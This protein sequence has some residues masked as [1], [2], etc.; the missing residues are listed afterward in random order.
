MKQQVVACLSCVVFLT[1]VTFCQQTSPAVK[2]ELQQ[3][4]AALN[5]GDFVAAEQHFSAAVKLAPTAA[6]PHANLGLA[7][8]RDRQYEKAVAEFKEAQRLNPSLAIA[9]A[10]VPLSQA[11]GGDCPAAMTGL[12][13]EF[14]SNPDPKLRRILGLSLQRCADQQGN[15]MESVQATQKLLAA[16]PNDPDVLYAAGELYGR[17]S[18]QV[19]LKLMKVAPKSARSYQVM[20]SFAATDGNWKGALDAYRQAAALDPS[21]VG[22]H[23]QIAI[24]LLTNSPDA[25]A[26]HE[27]LTELNQ[28]LKLD[29][30]SAQAEYEIGEVY[31]KHGQLNEAVT[32]FRQA[33]EINPSATPARLGL[34]KALL[35]LGEKTEALS[36]LEPAAKTDP[37]DPSVHFLLA[38]VYRELGRS[39]EAAH[40]QAEFERLKPEK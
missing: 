3:G 6:D 12:V 27:A 8:Y 20:A 33:L 4:Q 39:S 17:L 15:E 21:L 28:E 5:N 37:D 35:Q 16:Y 18:S 2:A 34:G 13:R 10:Y 1:T 7:Y 36:A 38:Q 25:D 11:A 9:K 40:E 23:L 14:G 29:P 30:R 24:L 22:V 19:Y 31:R 32:A 26:W